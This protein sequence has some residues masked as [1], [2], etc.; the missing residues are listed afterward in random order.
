MAHT[1]IAII[2]DDPLSVRLIRRQMEK[3]GFRSLLGLSDP[4]VAVDALEAFRPDVVLM[5]VVM[6]GLSGLELPL[7]CGTTPA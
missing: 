2:D 1:Q 4:T 7:E 5:D 3:L 6:P